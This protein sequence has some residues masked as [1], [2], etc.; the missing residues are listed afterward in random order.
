[1][2]SQDLKA[3]PAAVVQL[4]GKRA[5]QQLEKESGFLESR[6]S[7]R[8]IVLIYRLG[9][10][11]KNEAG[12]ETRILREGD[13]TRGRLHYDFAGPQ[14]AEKLKLRLAQGFT[15]ILSA[16]PDSIKGWQ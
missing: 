2:M 10:T 4:C 14:V 9:F 5:G 16:K 6:K 1:M 13:P 8:F 15:F 11:E 3:S 7:I 12:P